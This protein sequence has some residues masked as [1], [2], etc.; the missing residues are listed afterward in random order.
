MPLVD[1][2]VWMVRRE[3]VAP[4]VWEK[5]HPKLGRE[6]LGDNQVNV[7]QLVETT[8]EEWVQ[9]GLLKGVTE[10]TL[11]MEREVGHVF[12]VGLEARREV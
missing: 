12:K 2:T 5:S 3:Q 6:V 8:M 10:R 7:T 4:V 11:G 1:I 9:V